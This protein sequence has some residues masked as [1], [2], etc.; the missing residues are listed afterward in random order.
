MNIYVCSPY[1]GKNT[2]YH[3]AV[4][5]CKF[6]TLYG[7]TPFASHVMLHGILDDEAGRK[8]GLQAGIDMITLCDEVWVFCED[9]YTT[10]EGMDAEIWEAVRTEKRVV[11]Y[12][13]TAQGP[14]EEPMVTVEMR[15]APPAAAPAPSMADQ[16]QEFAQVEAIT[17][18][19]LWDAFEYG[20]AEELAAAI[21]REALM[22]A[23][24]SGTPPTSIYGK[25]ADIA[26]QLG[27]KRISVPAIIRTLGQIEP[28][29]R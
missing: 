26:L 9:G 12:T 29:N 8:A 22:R 6:V 11:Y 13:V 19:K 16:T 17:F 2:N 1:G 14:E 7:H 21:K 23:A 24:Q 4:A 18:C 10:T 20:P 25:L 28:T 5:Y 3:K 27:R 15:P